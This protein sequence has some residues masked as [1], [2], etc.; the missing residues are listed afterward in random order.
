M[1]AFL[2]AA[3]IICSQG[4]TIP[5]VHYQTG[6]CDGYYATYQPYG[7]TITRCANITDPHPIRTMTH[8]FVHHLDLTYGVKHP[9]VTAEQWADAVANHLLGVQSPQADQA[10]QQLQEATDGN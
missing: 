8:E 3:A 1:I 7:H 5:P 10:W 9:G 6:Q 2:L 4:V